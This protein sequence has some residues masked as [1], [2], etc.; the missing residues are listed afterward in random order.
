MLTSKELEK[1]K[2][3][4]NVVLNYLLNHDSRPKNKLHK[5]L[6]EWIM[7]HTIFTESLKCPKD[8]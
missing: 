3:A 6:E 2:T 7:E 5:G 4:T 1:K 8:H